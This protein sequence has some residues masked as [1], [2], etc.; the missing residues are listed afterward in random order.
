MNTARAY[1]AALLFSLLAIGYSAKAQIHGVEGD[2]V[3][4]APYRGTIDSLREATMD[5]GYGEVISHI[6]AV[7]SSLNIDSTY[8]LYVWHDPVAGEPWD[9]SVLRLYSGVDAS[10]IEI[11]LTNRTDQASAYQIQSPLTAERFSFR[12]MNTKTLAQQHFVLKFRYKLGTGSPTTFTR[13]VRVAPTTATFLNVP[14]ESEA[15]HYGTPLLTV[16]V[17]NARLVVRSGVTADMIGAA[18]VYRRTMSSAVAPRYDVVLPGAAESLFIQDVR[19]FRRGSDSNPY[20]K[21]AYGTPWPGHWIGYRVWSGDVFGRDATWFDV[22]SYPSATS[23]GWIARICPLNLSATHPAA[24]QYT[25]DQNNRVTSI[26]DGG[27]PN[28]TITLTRNPTTGHVESISTSDGRS[29]AVQSDT[30]GRVTGIVP[31]TSGNGARYFKYVNSTDPATMYRITQVRLGAGTGGDPHDPDLGDEIMYKFVYDAD[32]DLREEWRH[33][34]GALRKVVEHVVADDHHRY[35]KDWF[36]TGGSSYRLRDFHYENTGD[37]NR[38]LAHRLASITTYSEPAGGGTSYTTTFVHQVGQPTD[39][40]NSAGTMV[41]DHVDLPDGTTVGYEYNSHIGTQSCNFG[42][43]SKAI[44]T[45]SSGTLVT[46]DIDY[47]FFYSVGSNTRLFYAPR[48][49]RER[50]GRGAATEIVSDY[51]N[52]DSDENNDGLKGED[53]NHLLRRTGPTITLG[54]S[55]TRTPE[56]RYFY[57]DDSDPDP[58]VK[59]VLK[60][61]ET[62]YASGALRDVSYQ[63]DSLLRRT[64]E[65]VAPGGSALVTEYQ[66]VD[67]A[68]TQDRIVIDPDDY[69]T[70]TQFDPDGRVWKIIR[71][72]SPGGATGNYYQ[73]EHVYD[74]N[75]R[76]DQQLVDNKDQSGVAIS[77]ETNPI[78]TEYTYDRL[79]RL[80]Q[81]VVD[82]AN[83]GTTSHFAYNWLGQTTRLYDTS[84]RGVKRVFDGRGLVEEEIPLAAGQVEVPA[85]TTTFTYDAVGRLRFTDR[86]TGAQEEIAYDDFGRVDK[87]IR[88]P[89]PDGGAT[90][91]TD[92]DYDAASHLTRTYVSEFDG[93]TTYGLSDTTHQYDEG[94]FRYETRQRIVAGVDNGTDPITGRSG[95]PLMQW[96]FDWAGNVTEERSLGDATTGGQDRVITTTYDDANRVEET[97]DSESGQTI[98]ARDDRG[99][100]EQLQVKLAGA[101]YALT[102]TVYDALSRPTRVTDPEDASGLRH[103]HERFYDSRGNLRR[104]TAKDSAGT[105]IQT[106]IFKYDAAGRMQ[107]QAVLADATRTTLQSRAVDRVVDFV[108]DADGRLQIRKTYSAN[109]PIALEAATAYDDLGRVEYVYDA[110]LGYT[111]NLYDAANGRLAAREIRDWLGAGGLRTVTFDYDG[112]DRIIEQTAAG[113]AGV[114]DLVTTL[115]L[116]GLNRTIRVTDPKGVT[117]RTDYDLTGQRVAVVENEGGDELKRS[118]SYNYNRLNQ[119]I[120]QT[121][122]NKASD[123]TALADQVTHY[124]YDTLGRLLRAIFPDSSDDPQNAA[125]TDCVRMTYDDAG[126]MDTRRDQRGLVT[127]YDYDDRGLLLSRTTGGNVD[128]F[129]YDA[130]GRMLSADRGSAQVDRDYTDLGDIDYETQTY[131]AGTPRTVDYA[132]DQA[133]NRTQLTYPNSVAIDYTHT[134]LNGVKTMD[135]GGLFDVAYNYQISGVS[136]GLQPYEGRWP[137][138][139][140]TTTDAA[141]GNTVY[142]VGL[143]FDIHRRSSRQNNRL[144]V[145]GSPTTIADYTYTHDLAGNPL[146]QSTSGM[147]AFSADDRTFAVDDLDRLIATTYA[148]TAVDEE[149][150]F[151]LLGNREAHIDRARQ[152]FTYGAVNAANE[153]ASIDDN[154]LTYDAAG[155]LTVDEDGRQY[156]YDEFNR[157]TEVRTSGNAVLVRYTYDALGRRVLSEFSPNDP[158]NAYTIRYVYDGQ[159]IIEERDGADALTFYH[160]NGAQYIDE[161]IATYT[162]TGTRSGEF[163]YYLAG[164]NY[165]VTGRG[166]SDG[167]VIERIDFGSG[168]DFAKG[169]AG[170]FAHDA[171]PDLDIDLADF[172]SLQICF[173]TTD[174]TCLDIH[175]F[176]LDGVADGVIDID[177]FDAFAQCMNGPELPPQPGCAVVPTLRNGTPPPT[178]TF[179]LHGRPIDVLAD[180]KVLLYVR[181]RFYDPQHGRWFQRDPAGFMGGL[182]LYESFGSNAIAQTDPLGLFDPELMRYFFELR[183]GPHA[184]AF[185][186]HLEDRS[187]FTVSGYQDRWWWWD[188][189]WSV[190]QWGT[191]VGTIWIRDALPDWDAA[192]ALFNALNDSDIQWHYRRW[193]QEQALDAGDLDAYVAAYQEHM[194]VGLQQ[195]AAFAAMAAELYLAGISVASEGADWVVTISD[196]SAGKANWATAAAFLP[197]VSAGTVKVVGSSGELLG[198]FDTGSGAFRALSRQGEEL[199][200]AARGFH[201][202]RSADVAQSVLRGIDPKYFDPKARFGAA[203]YLAEQP[204]TAVAELASRGINATHGIRYALRAQA[205]RVLDLT[206]AATAARWGYAGGEISEATIGIGKRARE[207]GFNVIR[208][209]SVRGEGAN[210]AIFANFDDILVPQMVS[211]VA[212]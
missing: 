159:R 114:G 81:M 23:T 72:L 68:S 107:Y 2:D 155:N 139:R 203:F 93:S 28:N 24:Q 10:G 193:M 175:D 70:K 31:T 14:A 173:G 133:G 141:G 157:L 168:G 94:G 149:S 20:S 98:Y 67:D 170:S 46:Y 191:A 11:D 12:A 183:Y 127:S 207:A 29:W 202:A 15:F 153:Y 47:E 27:T 174:P 178:G 36:G 78:V 138:T 100:V 162:V 116:D 118:T 163:T 211:P 104:E 21:S 43:R 85:L 69:W 126:R 89:G 204:G 35:R 184:S 158:P 180:G 115:Q 112:H 154:P 95:D 5:I 4:N 186:R 187:V 64:F 122:A 147:S 92:H 48:V 132:H 82:P 212:P 88:H 32:G 41:L 63:Y 71:Y 120:T 190:S 143:G 156:F 61:V 210:L 86:P 50:D 65:T 7:Y 150:W 144:E 169:P 128:S 117:T 200:E 59:R 99:N 136:G 55:G 130:L 181:A 110:S 108:Y 52:G 73:I 124:R 197:L 1:L 54:Y 58:H 109:S 62:D 172:A 111:K 91:T 189:D 16:A 196:I 131:A 129:G 51:E 121:A 3:L 164:S 125:C 177:D 57:Y 96:K 44:H 106:T 176:D 188:P 53:S 45:G 103:Y 87:R 66:Y 195:G 56:T 18:Y 192:E 113:A 74:A 75:G 9:R 30:E 165:S 22:G 83:I 205:M 146:T 101:A 40:P 8:P 25:Y 105:P 6:E 145:A 185:L 198:R 199:G 209:P 33:V 167:S 38:P 160:V 49:V 42:L 119:L 142:E 182:N 26:R 102:D 201:A 77:G 171:E 152:T 135:I 194:R 151:D 37:P 208:F 80:T 206:D 60:R 39:P 13:H 148:E 17:G 166:N 97:T 137:E 140:R 179:A 84:G 79:G 34:D 123:G 161:R 76:L 90:I 134:R 19:Q